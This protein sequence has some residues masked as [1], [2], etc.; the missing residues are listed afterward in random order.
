MAGR[1]GRSERGGRVILQTFL[2]EHPVIRFAAAHD[3]AGFYA[4][5][6]EQRKRL[7]YPPFSKLARLEFRHQDAGAVESQVTR[8][9]ARL[10]ED[11]RTFKLS[12]TELIG[13]TPCFFAKINGLYRWQMVLRG[14][15]PEA[16]ARNLKLG[17]GWRVEVEPVSLL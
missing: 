1:A 4:R 3:Y 12:E 8:L 7:G 13:P 6:L 15:Q 5:E 9:A 11:I 17:E 14:P 16:L 2:P 10:A